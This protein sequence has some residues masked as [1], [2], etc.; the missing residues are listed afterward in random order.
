MPFQTLVFSAL[1]MIFMTGCKVIVVVPEHGSVVSESG[2]YDCRE[3]ARCEID[4]ADFLFDESFEARPDPGYEFSYWLARERGLCAGSAEVCELSTAD[5]EVSDGLTALINSDEIFYLQPVFRR[6]IA[7]Y[8]FSAVACL[9]PELTA[10]GTRISASY[11]NFN[12]LSEAG[13]TTSYVQ[14]VGAKTVFYGNRAMSIITDS[15]STGDEESVKVSETFISSDQRLAQVFD[16]GEISY[17]VTGNTDLRTL[18]FRSPHSVQSF[19]MEAGDI[20]V[21]RWDDRLDTWSLLRDVRTIKYYRSTLYSG[22]ESVTV[23]AGT[24]NTCRFELSDNVEDPRLGFSAPTTTLWYDV[25]T[26]MLVKEQGQASG[27]TV[28]ESAEINGRVLK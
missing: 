11:S 25:E 17:K 4:V 27:L 8:D 21:Q 18:L 20:Y 28:L 19:D 1:A 14:E 13:T 2:N 6:E 15:I 9:N 22:R 5:Y 26:G 10:E 24:F 12:A 7:P 23:P 3:G 16:Y